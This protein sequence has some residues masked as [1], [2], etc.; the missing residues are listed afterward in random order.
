MSPLRMGTVLL[1]AVFLVVVQP[2][3][4]YAQ[5][6]NLNDFIRDY[7]K[8]HG[9][10]GT[11]LVQKSGKKIYHK[12]FGEANLTFHLPLKNDTKYKIASITKTFT[13]VLILQLVEQGKVDLQ[14]PLRTYLPNY[15]GEAADKVTLHHLLNHT[16]GLP[17]I[18][19]VGSK[20]DVIKNGVEHYQRPFT[21]DELVV[22]FCSGKLVNEPGKVFDY[23][24]AD[25]IILGKII[26]AVTGKSYE[27][28]L[29]QQILQP[30][31]MENSG[32]LYHYNIVENLAE[33]YFWRDDLKQ[34][35]REL[36]VYIENWYAAGA[37][38]ATADDLLK[39]ANALFGNRL[40]KPETV[41]QMLTPGLDNYGYSVWIRSE[42][43]GGHKYTT[44]ERYGQIMGAN[45]VL[46]RFPEKDLTILLLGNTDATNVGDF[47]VEIGKQLL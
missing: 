39:F 34:L 41:Q 3:S 27:Q 4:V 37:M 15:T 5:A 20:E 23:N 40:V 38:Y 25:Y 30:L 14:K 12:S 13:A 36:P 22:R 44:I 24:N 26:E 29:Q 10:S 33:S 42:T 32:L 2:G 1:L 18:D 46:F 43:I 28:V 35:V 6:K 45:L 8:S 11:I 19:K 17:N 7:G 16:S 9:F 47:A 21:T 31:K